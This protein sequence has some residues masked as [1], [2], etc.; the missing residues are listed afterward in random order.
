MPPRF[1]DSVRG[2]LEMRTAFIAAV[3]GSLA[4]GGTAYAAKYLEPDQVPQE[5][6][7][8]WCSANSK[9]NNGKPMYDK[10]SESSKKT[11][12]DCGEGI[13][14]IGRRSLTGFEHGCSYV[15][16]KAWIDPTGVYATKTPLGTPVARLT[17]K[18]AGEGCSWNETLFLAYQKGTM[19]TTSFTWAMRCNG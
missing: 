3:L 2:E 15:E 10:L 5:F 13:L 8:D 19:T 7:G 1:G 6:L 16:V 14:K 4:L 17:S 9:D 11:R 12:E 18:C